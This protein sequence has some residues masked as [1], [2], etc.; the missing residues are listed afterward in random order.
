MI[1]LYEIVRCVLVLGLGGHGCFAG[2]RH[3]GPAEALRPGRGGRLP[4]F[5]GR[6]LLAHLIVRGRDARDL[7]RLR[8]RYVAAG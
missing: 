1:V 7:L 6:V 5:G 8:R 3:A 2:A 4:V